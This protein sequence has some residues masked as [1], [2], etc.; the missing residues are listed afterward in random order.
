MLQAQQVRLDLRRLAQ[1]PLHFGTRPV[2]T[3]NAHQQNPPTE[4]SDIQGN[5]RGAP[6]SAAP[7]GRTQHRDRRLGR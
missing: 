5:V 2:R 4:I 6:Q 7:A 1:Q 3:D